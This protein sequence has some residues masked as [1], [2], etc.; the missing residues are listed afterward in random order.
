[1]K[2]QIA[3][4]IAEYLQ[5]QIRPQFSGRTEYGSYEFSSRGATSR[6]LMPKFC[7]EISAEIFEKLLP[8][9]GEK[10]LP[11]SELFD[12]MANEHGLTL[13]NTELGD[14]IHIARG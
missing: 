7:Q 14:I 2:D 9:V 8:I 5:T 4:I 10:D 3:K 1:M 12:H 11:L 6:D 13:T